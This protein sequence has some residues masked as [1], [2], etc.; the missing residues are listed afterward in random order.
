MK[1]LFVF[2]L[3]L[4]SSCIYLTSQTKQACEGSVKV[5]T[6]LF[7]CITFFYMSHFAKVYDQ[8]TSVEVKDFCVEMFV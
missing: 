8:R 4:L 1:N 2:V 6:I 5:I 3:L 7:P